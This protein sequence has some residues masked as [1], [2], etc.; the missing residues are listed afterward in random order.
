MFIL[1]VVQHISRFSN[2][3]PT[4][5]VV[6]VIN[7]PDWCRSEKML[8]QREAL[9]HFGFSYGLIIF[10]YEKSNAESSAKPKNVGQFRVSK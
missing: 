6:K 1:Y 10:G 9:E 5:D 2:N 3:D 7:Y 8:T 4:D